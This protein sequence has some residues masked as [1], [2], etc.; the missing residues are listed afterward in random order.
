MGKLFHRILLRYQLNITTYQIDTYYTNYTT[1]IHVFWK[2]RK[3]Y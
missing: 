3:A 2:Q 1:Y